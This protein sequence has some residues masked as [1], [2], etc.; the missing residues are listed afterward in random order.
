MKVWYGIDNPGEVGSTVVYPPSWNCVNLYSNLTIQREING[1]FTKPF[2][3]QTS[4]LWKSLFYKWAICNHPFESFMKVS[5]KADLTNK[6]TW[7]VLC[8]LSEVLT[9]YYL[10]IVSL[11]LVWISSLSGAS[12]GRNW[13]VKVNVSYIYSLLTELTAWYKKGTNSRERFKTVMYAKTDSH[14]WWNRYPQCN[15]ITRWCTNVHVGCS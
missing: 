1:N 9:V 7:D 8:E 6:N 15:F 4:K 2:W 3:H 12:E 10:T 13:M 11:W 14:T 5:M